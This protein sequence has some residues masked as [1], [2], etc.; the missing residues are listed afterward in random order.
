[1]AVFA[2]HTAVHALM[3][4]SHPLDRDFVTIQPFV[5]CF[6][7]VK[8]CETTAVVGRYART[9][10]PNMGVWAARD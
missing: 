7:C 3:T 10:C 5:Y 2:H 1:V 4:A 9:V 8:G 6:L